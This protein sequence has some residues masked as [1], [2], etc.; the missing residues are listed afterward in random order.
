MRT[1][2]L[3]QFLNL[4][5]TEW[6][7][8]Q[9]LLAIIAAGN[10]QDRPHATAGDFASPLQAGNCSFMSGAR[11]W[12]LTFCHRCRESAEAR[13]G[14]GLCRAPAA[15][16]SRW[17]GKA[18]VSWLLGQF[19][20]EASTP[21]NANQCNNNPVTLLDYNLPICNAPTNHG[22]VKHRQS[23]LCGQEVLGFVRALSISD[24]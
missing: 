19:A 7:N 24:A 2:I 15:V 13:G 3:V 12:S 5:I 16:Y 17:C 9:Q 1:Q 6:S 10:V 8:K 4:K 21:I 22:F 23:W 18:Q 11:R 14:H 20:S